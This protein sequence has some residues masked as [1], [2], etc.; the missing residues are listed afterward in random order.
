MSIHYFH[1][2]T[3]LPLFENVDDMWLKSVLGYNY[4]VIAELSRK[5]SLIAIAVHGEFIYWLDSNK[6]KDRLKKMPK[7]KD[8]PKTISRFDRFYEQLSDVIVVNRSRIL[9]WLSFSS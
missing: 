3:C 7:R 5:Y 9:G 8:V 6:D 4:M 1:R 2:T